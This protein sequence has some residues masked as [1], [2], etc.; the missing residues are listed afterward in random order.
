M[1]WMGDEPMSHENLREQVLTAL[2]K[3]V[4]PELKRDIVSAGMVK[5]VHVDGGIVKFTLELTTPACPLREYLITAAKQ[6]V[7]ALEW[8]EKVEVDVTARVPQHVRSKASMPLVKNIIAV[9]SGKGG[10]GKTTIAVNV[11][12]ALSQMGAKVGLL[13]GDIYGPNVPRMLGVQGQ[14]KIVSGKLIPLSSWGIKV[15][16]IGFFIDPDTPVIWRGPMLHKAVEQLL[17]DVEWGELDYL[18]VDLP[19][20]TGDVQI[21][22]SQLIELSGA[23][24]VTTPQDVALYDALK[25]VSMFEKTKTPILGI[26]ENM[27]YFICPNCGHRTEL[28]PRKSVEDECAKRKIRYLGSIPFSPELSLNS[29]IGKPIVVTEP[30]SQVAIALYEVARQV[31][32]SVSVTTLS[33]S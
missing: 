30:Q 33:Q 12:V 28:F 31:A 8:V 27:S 9:G 18:F 2:S 10:V 14:P 6:A 16:S 29:D 15:M 11:A 23:I 17:Y 3:V 1:M 20:G 4:D 13:D 25:S 21:S 24:I 5:D 7:E 26:V 19:P 22:L 32:A